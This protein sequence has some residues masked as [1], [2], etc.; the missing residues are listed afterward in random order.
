MQ[1]VKITT[2]STREDIVYQFFEKEIGQTKALKFFV[3]ELSKN[4]LVFSKV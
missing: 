3:N 4:F 2:A 1:H